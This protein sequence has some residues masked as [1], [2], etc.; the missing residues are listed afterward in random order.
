MYLVLVLLLYVTRIGESPTGTK[1]TDM[2]LL[3]TQT[4]FV[5]D[6]A[7]ILIDVYECR[8][9]PYH[10]VAEYDLEELEVL[11][12]ESRSG[13]TTLLI[14]RA[15]S[16]ND[17]LKARTAEYTGALDKHINTYNSI[18]KRRADGEMRGEER[19]LVEKYLLVDERQKLADARAKVCTAPESEV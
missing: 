12:S 8:L 10:V 4:I 9:L 15:Q 13:A 7:I 19:L 5:V 16:W 3:C 14:S 1:I 6:M 2:S 11:P 18:M 17:T